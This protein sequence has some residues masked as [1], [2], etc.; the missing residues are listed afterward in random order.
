[1]QKYIIQNVKIP[2]NCNNVLDRVAAAVGLKTS[3]IHNLE[4]YKQSLD[5]RIKKQV[6]YVCSFVFEAPFEPPHRA[7]A[8]NEPPDALAPSRKKLFGKKCIIV[9]AGPA[10]LFLAR[11]L[12]G[13]GVQVTVI[14]RG[15]NLPRRSRDVSDYFVQGKFSEKS[16]VQFGLGGAGT[17]SDGKLTCGNSSPLIRTVFKEFVRNGAPKDIMYS[18]LPHIGTDNLVGVVSSIRDRII[19]GGGEFYFDTLVTDLIVRGGKVVGVKAI[20]R[21][22]S[23]RLMADCVCICTGNS[24]RDV[25]KFLFRK[26]VA[27]EFKPFAVGLRIEHR[28]KFIDQTQFGELASTHRD[29]QSASYKLAYNGPNRSCYSFCM[30]PGGTVIAANSTPRTV[31]TNGMSNYARDAEN[32][33]SALVVS[34]TKQDVETWGYGSDALAGMRFQ[35][36]MERKAYKMGGGKYRAPTQNVADFVNNTQS[37]YLQ[38][39]TSYP[40]GNTIC[41]LRQLYPAEITSCLIDGLNAFNKRMTDFGTTGILVGVETRTSA[42]VRIVR[43]EDFQSVSHPN[44]FPVGEG[45][46]YAGGIVSSAVDGLRVGQAVVDLL[47]KD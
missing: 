23:F 42:P 40:R 16:N 34:V 22:S 46:G 25:Y 4:L 17:F 47:S 10:G 15:S 33:N 36:D 9:G 18:S 13:H 37:S 21:L 38:I 43:G 12:T 44:L 45:A 29:L 5:A 14:E 11:Y 30:C 39:P 19:G 7:V 20:N 26:K 24:A 27:M 8:Y 2:L 41:N 28:R 6:H 32:S 3:L 31:V 35:E 1:M